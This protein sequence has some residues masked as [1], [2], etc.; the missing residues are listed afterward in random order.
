MAEQCVTQQQQQPPP[1]QEQAQQPPPPPPIAAFHIVF[2][3]EGTPQKTR[4]KRAAKDETATTTTTTRT[5]LTSL[6]IATT[7]ARP[8]AAKTMATNATTPRPRSPNKPSPGK[9]TKLISSVENSNSVVANPSSSYPMLGT[10]PPTPAWPQGEKDLKRKTKDRAKDLGN[11]LPVWKSDPSASKRWTKLGKGME[12]E[13]QEPSHLFSQMTYEQ[14]ASALKESAN[15]ILDEL[16][17][18]EQ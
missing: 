15:R 5:P 12:P 2:P 11:T 18:K 1:P 8:E 6:V 4:K 14:K 16:I 3:V 17:N 10:P 13:L 9:K 7:T